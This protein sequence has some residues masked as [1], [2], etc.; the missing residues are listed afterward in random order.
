V[1]PQVALSL[2]TEFA[3]GTLQPG[4]HQEK[5]VTNLLDHVIAWSGALK[6]LRPERQPVLSVASR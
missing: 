2:F 6:T 5:A 3:T 4:P 1:G